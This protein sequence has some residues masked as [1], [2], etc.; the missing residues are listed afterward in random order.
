VIDRFLYTDIHLDMA[1]MIYFTT[2]YISSK[3]QSTALCRTS[4]GLIAY[5]L[6]KHIPCSIQSSL[7]WLTLW[8]TSDHGY[9]VTG[10]LY[11]SL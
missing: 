4:H 11:Q 10:W 8:F 9:H 6:T 1:W 3:V 2:A 7:S 5:G